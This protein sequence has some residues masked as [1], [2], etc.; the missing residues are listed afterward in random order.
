MEYYFKRDFATDEADGTYKNPM[1]DLEIVPDSSAHVDAKGFLRA[2]DGQAPWP[3]YVR[4][5][6]DPA[7]VWLR[8]AAVEAGGVAPKE[9]HYWEVFLIMIGMVILFYLIRWYQNC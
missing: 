9:R 3:T 5:L 7:S 4:T 6:S 1:E 8:S 2:S